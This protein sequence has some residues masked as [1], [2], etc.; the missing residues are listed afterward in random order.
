MV[1]GR[2]LLNESGGLLVKAFFNFMEFEGL[3]VKALFNFMEIRKSELDYP[4]GALGMMPKL[5]RRHRKQ[6][7]IFEGFRKIALRGL[8]RPEISRV[9]FRGKGWGQKIVEFGG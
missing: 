7:S 2:V 4:E 6:C 9:K 5:E 3:L 1:C 8:S